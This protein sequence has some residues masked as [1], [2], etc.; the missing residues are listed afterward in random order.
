RVRDVASWIGCG[1]ACFGLIAAT[2][3]V[4][5]LWFAGEIP[6]AA[7][8]AAWSRWWLADFGAT[9]VIGPALLVAWRG[10]PR[11]RELASRVEVWAALAAVGAAAGAAFGTTL[12]GPAAWFGALLLI[13]FVVW[14]GRGGSRT[15]VFASTLAAVIAVV[16]TAQ[17]H[18][19]FALADAQAGLQL[20]GTYAGTLTTVA[21]LVAAAVSERELAE[22]ERDRERDERQRVELKMQEA[23]RLE[24]LGMLAGGVAHD[25]NNILA[26]IT[27]NTQILQIAAE[28]GSE[29]GQMLADIGLAAG[30]AADLCHRLLAYAGR[31]ETRAAPVRLSELMGDVATILTASLPK[32]VRIVN[33]VD[34]D[35]EPVEGDASQLR[36]VLLNLVA[37]AAE[38]IGDRTGEVYVTSGSAVL[39]GAELHRMFGV[40]DAAPERFVFV[41]IADTGSGMSDEVKSRMF[42][43]F[44]TTK[45]RG[46]GLG[47]AAVLGI[48]KSHRGAVEVDTLPGCG[49]SVRVHLRPSAVPATAAGKRPAVALP[50]LAGLTVLIADDE[51][52]VLTMLERAFRRAGCR[53]VLARNGGE[54]VDRFAAAT[55]AID[56]VLMDVSMPRLGGIAA[57]EAIRALAPAARVVLM[58]GYEEEAAEGRA[59]VAAFLRKPF[60]VDD[61]LRTIAA[62]AVAAVPG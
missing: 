46:N 52:F 44:F 45:A 31:V 30:R 62:A 5:G 34:P 9:L 23:Q 51:P 61:A 29:E 3:A 11:L 26:A 59:G 2:I 43:P 10:A 58:S 15:A 57:F 50:R 48:V 28:P 49:T 38:S 39:R 36:Q 21:L 56:V 27:G 42:D 20:L 6:A 47:L 41:D 18:G 12:A 7:V 32:H 13:P 60:A 25:F 35:L 14:I 53:V 4:V 22:R 33:L 40:A 55:T 19:P 37:N 8:A 54:A 24:S 16:G 17:G 1:A